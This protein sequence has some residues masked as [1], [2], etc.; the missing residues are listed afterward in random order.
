[1]R[2]QHWGP[3]LWF[4]A[5]ALALS[6]AVVRY[7]RSGEISWEITAAGLFLLAMG[8]GQLKR[9]PSDAAPKPP[10]EP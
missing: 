5:A 6:A 10:P 8:V 4:V 3:V 9:P 2:F 1:M 7:V